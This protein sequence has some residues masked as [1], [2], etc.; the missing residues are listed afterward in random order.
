MSA[1][2]CCRL[3][4]ARTKK[5][6]P[7][8]AITPS[9]GHQQRPGH[10]RTRQPVETRQRR[11]QPGAQRLRGP[12]HERVGGDEMALVP[13]RR[14]QRHA[15]N[16]RGEAGGQADAGLEPQPGVRLGLAS[17]GTDGRRSQQV[18]RG[19]RGGLVAHVADRV[20]HRRHV[21]HRRVVADRRRVE[22]QV[23][24]GGADPGG[25]GERAL[26]RA[27]AGRAGHSGHRKRD[28]A[29][30]RSGGGGGGRRGL[31]PRRDRPAGT[32]SSLLPPCPGS[33]GR[34]A[35][36]GGDQPR[37]MPRTSSRRRSMISGVVPSRFRRSSGSVFDAL[38]L[39]CQ[40]SNS[41]EMPSSR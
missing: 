19:R 38:T 27:L 2:P 15:E 34:M 31:E 18:V 4:Q 9:G 29:S 1:A 41:T 10:G 25:A 8:Q 35:R 40:S 36:V 23:D 32:S 30:G 39:K 16:H 33:P 17:D 22:H 21:D 13:G 5:S 14:H 24:A 11:L 12:A 3:R 37:M 7:A 6:R 20:E 28:P 26:D